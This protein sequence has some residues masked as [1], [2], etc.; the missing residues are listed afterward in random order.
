MTIPIPADTKNAPGA[1]GPYSQA[2]VGNG[3]LFTSGQLPIDPETKAM[4][5][6]IREQAAMAL[7]NLRGILQAGGSGTKRF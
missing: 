5:Q 4:P 6:G 2:L 1:V 7:M 3:L